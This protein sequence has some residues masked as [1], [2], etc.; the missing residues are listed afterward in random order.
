[1]QNMYT[2]S[3]N[4]GNVSKEL[5]DAQSKADKLSRKTGNAEKMGAASGKL[6]SAQQ[7]WDSQAPFVYESLQ[8]L[9]ESRCNQLRDVLT[10]YQTHEADHAEQLQS[11][12][13]ETLALMLDVR[14]ETEIENFVHSITSGKPAPMTRTSTRRRSSVAVQQASEA[15]APAPLSTASTGLSPP[16]EDPETP[17]KKSVAPSEP[18]DSFVDDSPAQAEPKVGK[19]RRLGTLFGGRKRQSV[20]G[21]FGQLSPPKGGPTFGRLGSS[22]KGVSPRASLGNLN[23]GR[24]A[25]LT[26][27]PNSPPQVRPNTSNDRAV[28]GVNGHSSSV[29]PAIPEIAGLSSSKSN[30]S[31]GF[32]DIASPPPGP[33]PGQSQKDSEGFNVR[34]PLS[35]PISEAQ[36]EAAGGEEADQLLKL[37]IHDQPVAEEDPQEKQAA[38]SSVA[39]T[40]K[41]G[42]ATKRSGT[43]R[44]RRDVRNTIYQPVAALGAAGAADTTLGSFATSNSFESEADLSKS[45]GP[46][47][48][49]SSTVDNQSIRSGTSLG[50]LVHAAHPDMHGPGLNS[51]II[52]TVSVNFDDSVIKN[53]VVNGE[54]AFSYNKPDSSDPKSESPRMRKYAK[55][56]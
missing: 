29:A 40:L 10:Q 8:A 18:E 14:T 24:L 21:G 36:R 7:Q 47:Q 5:S 55:H 25:S 32:S 17:A 45:I 50:G 42:P 33:P 52:E 44:G 23:D 37:S 2:I 30:G 6:E 4:L 15:P 31:M 53:A 39:N 1:M 13:A 26:E 16:V 51:S 43:I 38:L 48:S 3:N 12:S 20:H 49:Q 9:D 11:I 56:V 41:M 27:D 46:G 28:E 35:D 34:A 19:L 22:G 54:I